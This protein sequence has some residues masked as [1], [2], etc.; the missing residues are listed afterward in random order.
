MEP[1]T[2]NLQ[3]YVKSKPYE[4]G[5]KKKSNDSPSQLFIEALMEIANK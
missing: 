3:V 2:K 4:R 1:W 5:S